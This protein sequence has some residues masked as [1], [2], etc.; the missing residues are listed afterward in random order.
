MKRN[1][2]G[3][4]D[5]GAGGGGNGIKVQAKG[6]RTGYPARTCRRNDDVLTSTRRQYD[7]ATSI[8]RHLDVMCRLGTYYSQHISLS[9]PRNLVIRRCNCSSGGGLLES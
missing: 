8:Q 1:D 9:S 7:D 6:M 3:L 5:G 4:L 2:V